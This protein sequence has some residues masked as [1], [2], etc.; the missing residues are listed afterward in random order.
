MSDKKTNK[1]RAEL[2]HTYYHEPQPDASSVTIPDRMVSAIMYAQ[3]QLDIALQ[4]DVDL[5]KQLIGATVAKRAVDNMGLKVEQAM[6]NIPAAIDGYIRMFNSQNTRIA[7]TKIIGEFFKHLES[8]RISIFDLT[9]D[10]VQSYKDDLYSDPRYSP[11]SVKQKL[12]CLGGFWRKGLMRDYPKVFTVNHFADMR[13][14]PIVD[15]YEK[16]VVTNTMFEAICKQ[17]LKDERQDVLCVVKF[18]ER[19]GERLDVLKNMRVHK[20]NLGWT[21]VSKG[22][23]RKGVLTQREFDEFSFWDT[24]MDENHD[25]VRSAFRRACEKLYDAGII[26]CKPSL[27][28]LRR[29]RIALD[30]KD[31]S[32]IELV[33]VSSRYHASIETTV[34]YIKTVADID[35]D[36]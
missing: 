10:I 35:F 12:G 14:E 13:F 16:D 36:V 18:L 26:D 25:Y 27:H 24:V 34:G 20:K 31:V 2:A 3:N 28:D 4:D 22:K 1:E 17:L 15:K 11:R 8:I 33:N 19:T 7:Y 9:R 6:I 32:G 21:S 29:R 5:Q 23:V 30:L